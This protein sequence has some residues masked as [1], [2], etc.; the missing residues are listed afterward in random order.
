[1]PCERCHRVMLVDH[2]LDLEDAHGHLWLRAWRCLNCGEAMEPGRVDHG[3][4]HQ[5]LLA[6]LCD[7]WAKP[8]AA[9]TEE[10][11]IGV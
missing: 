5:S 10:I 3:A 6:R 9:R 2:F 8:Q 1:M 7:R 11:P 4:V